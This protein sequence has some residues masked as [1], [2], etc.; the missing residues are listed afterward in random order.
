MTS[1]H[2]HP[3]ASLMT[4][5]TQKEVSMTERISPTVYEL[6]VHAD[7][8]D[9]DSTT[10]PGGVWLSDVYSAW[11]DVRDEYDDV[12]R[13]IWETADGSV[14]VSDYSCWLVFTD[15]GGWREDISDFGPPAEILSVSLTQV[16]RIVL[17]GI[18]ER[19]I[20]ALEMEFRAEQEE[21]A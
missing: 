5:T 2:P 16:A 15:L 20:S 21:E 10:S 7:V 13:M 19:L 11:E 1:S 18:A 4:T 9:P 14:P 3:A 8:C 17:C 6:S 12:E